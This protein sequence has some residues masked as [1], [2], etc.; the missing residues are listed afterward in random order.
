MQNK[1]DTNDSA[2]TVLL[3]CET[4]EDFFYAFIIYSNNNKV[5]S[6]ETKRF[7]FPLC[8]FCFNNHQSQEAALCNITRSSESSQT[9]STHEH[10]VSSNSDL[11]F[12]F[13]LYSPSLA[14]CAP[15][16]YQNWRADEL[17]TGQHEHGLDLLVGWPACSLFL[18]AQTGQRAD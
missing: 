6:P 14:T 16:V 13:S 5:N 8:Q 17:R 15:R 7:F 3:V 11:T 9:G 4:W 2:K 18:R 10:Q 12:I 1:V